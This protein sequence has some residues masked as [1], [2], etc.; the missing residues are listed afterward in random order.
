NLPNQP[1]NH[2]K[3]PNHKPLTTK[4]PIP[5]RPTTI[6]PT[7]ELPKTTRRRFPSKGSFFSGKISSKGKRNRRQ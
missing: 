2:H 7:T 1:Q 4:P 6:Q 5:N 3:T